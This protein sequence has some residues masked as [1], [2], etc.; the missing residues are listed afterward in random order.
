MSIY[1]YQHDILMN[2]LNMTP[3]ECVSQVYWVKYFAIKLLVYWIYKHFILIVFP[4]NCL[5]IAC[6]LI[7][8]GNYFTF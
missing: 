8:T 3:Y 1:L 5:A 7:S 6:A 2:A 4:K